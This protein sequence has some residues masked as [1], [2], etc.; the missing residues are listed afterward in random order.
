MPRHNDPVSVRNI[1]VSITIRGRDLVE[2]RNEANR[3]GVSLSKVIW[4]RAQAGRPMPSEGHLAVAKELQRIGVNLNLATRALL[5]DGAT[6]SAM[7]VEDTLRAVAQV[8]DQLR[9]L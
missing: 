4:L 8:Q 9:A 1:Q 7:A 2:W 5:R 6:A 3:M